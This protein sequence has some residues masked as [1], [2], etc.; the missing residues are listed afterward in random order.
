MTNKYTSD[1]GKK[2]EEKTNI[3]YGAKLSLKISS[4]FYYKKKWYKYIY[5][6]GMQNKYKSH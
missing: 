2:L 1:F 6:S 4:A 3:G 5:R